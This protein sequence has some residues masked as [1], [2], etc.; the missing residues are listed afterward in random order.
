MPARPPTTGRYNPPAMILRCSGLYCW[1]RCCRSVAFFSRSG[2][3]RNELSPH[4]QAL[5]Q[6]IARLK[7]TVLDRFRVYTHE[8][9]EVRSKPSSQRFWAGKF[10]CQVLAICMPPGRS[11]LPQA[12]SPPLRPPRT[13]NSYSACSEHPAGPLRKGERVGERHNRMIVQP[14]DIALGTIGMPP[15]SAL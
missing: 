15:V 14:L 7:A 5:H 2:D 8:P 10:P 12:N 13:A 4:H 9:G 11:E 3:Q 1:L 6:G